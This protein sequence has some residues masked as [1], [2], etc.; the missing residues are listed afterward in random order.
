M[1]QI[2]NASPDHEL[3]KDDN[4][5]HQE[6]PVPEMVED[7]LVQDGSPPDEAGLKPPLP[8][9]QGFGELSKH[10]V[11]NGPE[12]DASPAPGTPARD[13]HVLLRELVEKGY[14]RARQFT[15]KRTARETLDV[16]GKVL[17]GA[18]RKA[19]APSR[20]WRSEAVPAKP[21]TVPASPAPLARNIMRALIY[22]DLFHYPMTV[23][24]IRRQRIF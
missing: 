5:E 24:E 21:V 9:F 10:E 3:S 12:G 22:A 20:R 4:H 8:T 16:Y 6:A 19:A 14:E 2:E 11:G 1:L 7:L 18:R 23:E 13:S 17:R 15:W